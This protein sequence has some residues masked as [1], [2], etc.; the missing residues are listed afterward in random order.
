MSPRGFLFFLKRKGLCD[1]CSALLHATDHGTPCRRRA[2]ALGER[3]RR[4][5][6][7][8]LTY[9][10]GPMGCLMLDS[11]WAARV[12]TS[13][14]IAGRELP[15]SYA[16]AF[17]REAPRP[18]DVGRRVGDARDETRHWAPVSALEN[19]LHFCFTRD[20]H[21]TPYSSCTRRTASSCCPD[22]IS[23]TSSRAPPT[24]P[25]RR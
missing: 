5:W 15:T 19:S 20:H 12:T 14:F 23:N 3:D 1:G 17:D 2:R 7:P 8:D 13:D 4:V 6:A 21:E 24:R 18:S 25:R 16:C 9:R 22:R 10:T 11:L